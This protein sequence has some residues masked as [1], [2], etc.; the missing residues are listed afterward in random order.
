[1]YKMVVS[2]FYGA[3]IN[4][5]EAISL[6]TMIELDRI[7]KNGTIF[8]ITTSKSA[9][10]VIEYNKDFPFIDFVIAFNGSYIYDLNREVVI[11]DKCLG[12]NTIKKIYK[13]CSNYDLCFY[14]LDF[15]NYTGEYCDKDFSRKVNDVELFIENNKKSIYK[16]KVVTNSKMESEEVVKLL[17]AAKVKAELFVKEDN[18]FYVIEITNDSYN[19]LF[20]IEKICKL[21]RIHLKDVLAISSSVSSVDVIKN[22]GYGC[23]VENAS[24]E[25]KKIAKEITASNENNG[26]ERII[27]KYF[28]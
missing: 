9:R 26:V 20:G 28:A 5:E 7:R 8:S 27:K 13:L 15:C 22:C 6:S 14:S 12:V 11:F 2:D 24:E 4:S 21:N 25:I 18:G 19:K 16:I 3:L 17:K 10:Y 23:C 1:M